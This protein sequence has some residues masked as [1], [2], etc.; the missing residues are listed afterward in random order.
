MTF[1]NKSEGS[2]RHVD[3]WVREYL[4]VV[5]QKIWL[6]LFLTLALDV[7]LAILYRR[8]H[9]NVF[10]FVRNKLPG[11]YLFMVKNGCREN[12]FTIALSTYDLYGFPFFYEHLWV[13]R[14]VGN[15]EL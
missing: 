6:L 9:R 4:D 5:D 7:A 14:L 10:A 2:F 12:S 3:F 11:L 1:G 15:L 13:M 8:Y